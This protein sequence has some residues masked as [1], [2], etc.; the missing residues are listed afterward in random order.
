MY[1][2]TL[3][4]VFAGESLLIIEDCSFPLRVTKKGKFV[5]AKFF[6]RLLSDKIPFDACIQ[7]T[8]FGLINQLYSEFKKYLSLFHYN[9]KYLFHY[10]IN[11]FYT[12][13][14]LKYF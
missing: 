4:Q 12:C 8:D 11:D 7:N 14:H 9:K 3:G 5:F 13:Y 6:H 10:F 1:Y 2:N